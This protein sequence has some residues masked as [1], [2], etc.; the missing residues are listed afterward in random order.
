MA[1]ELFK[2]SSMSLNSPAESP[3]EPPT[4]PSANQ[5]A[6]PPTEPSVGSP[7]R[8]SAAAKFFRGNNFKLYLNI[9]ILAALISN[10][11]LL[12]WIL[13]SFRDS[14]AVT[15]AKQKYEI[16]SV[17]DS[18][19]G[20]CVD[21]SAL[22]GFIKESDVEVVK[23]KVFDY[24]TEKEKALP[25]ID[26]YKLV[27]L[28]A[29]ILKG[30]RPTDE[31]FARFWENFG[32]LVEDDFVLRLLQ[33]P[34]RDLA[35]GEVR[36]LFKLTFLTD[37]SCKECYDVKLHRN[38]LRNLSMKINDEETLDVSDA[39]GQSLVEKFKITLVPT[40]LLSGE[41]DEYES[42]QTIWPLVGTKEDDDAYVFRDG[43]PQ[44]GVHR[45]LSTGEIKEGVQN[46]T[47]VP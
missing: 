27:K 10:L 41:L 11:A 14:S 22:I 15:E 47:G 7:P 46:G 44:M 16:I 29:L 36:G 2:L 18:T 23:E 39:Q 25:L 3:T 33:P 32:D 45:D 35:S 43:V 31:A 28:P 34:Y 19:C 20:E 4:E 5:P 26:K 13:F 37:D 30:P 9:L 12:G 17:I 38:A 6:E 42:F 24:G 21:L 40:I 1:E 8:Q